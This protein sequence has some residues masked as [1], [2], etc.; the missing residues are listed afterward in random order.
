M[1]THNTYGVY[2]IIIMR[3]SFTLV[4][5]QA[6]RAAGAAFESS[7]RVAEAVIHWLVGACF[8][9]RCFVPF[10]IPA[11]LGIVLEKKEVQCDGFKSKKATLWECMGKGLCSPL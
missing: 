8:R 5:S 9:T 10:G 4:E 11:M 1:A 6:P 2:N 7:G 3:L